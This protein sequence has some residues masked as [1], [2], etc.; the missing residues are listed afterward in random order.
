MKNLA[1]TLVTVV[2]PYSTTLSSVVAIEGL[3]GVLW[4]SSGQ[5]LWFCDS[6]ALRW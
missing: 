2:A 4:I 6:D 3:V 1:L 5:W